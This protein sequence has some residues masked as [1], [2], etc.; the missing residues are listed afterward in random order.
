MFFILIY[1][2]TCIRLLTQLLGCLE[3]VLD[4]CGPLENKHLNFSE[5]NIYT[6]LCD[7]LVIG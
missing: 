2:M 1:D 7:Q 5:M 4:V 3:Y 6:V